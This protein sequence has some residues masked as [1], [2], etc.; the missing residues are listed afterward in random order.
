ML[1]AWTVSVAG[2]NAKL[3]MLTWSPLTGAAGAVTDIEAP[4]IEVMDG[5]PV[6]VGGRAGEHPA[7]DSTA[8]AATVRFRSMAAV[9]PSNRAAGYTA[10]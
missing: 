10:L 2:T 5:M 1:P 7:S 4:D 9:M 8:N 6:V 3:S